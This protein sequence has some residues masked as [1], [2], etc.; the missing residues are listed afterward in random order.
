[1]FSSQCFQAVD[2]IVTEVVDGELVLLQL[3]EGVYFGLDALG[4]EIWNWL[5]AGHSLAHITTSLGQLYP[6]QSTEAL[7]LDVH[8]LVNE[9]V[10]AKL[11]LPCAAGGR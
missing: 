11:L 1:M 6:A 4:T 5:V 9:L 7:E 10:D 3:D 2:A 8:A